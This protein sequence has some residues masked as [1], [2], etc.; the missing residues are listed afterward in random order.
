[1]RGKYRDVI[2]QW[3]FKK[4]DALLEPTKEAVLS[5]IDFQINTAELKE[6]DGRGLR[7]ASG[8]VFYNTSNG[9]FKSYIT[10]R[11]T[12]RLF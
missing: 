7:E 6:L 9:H 8:Y 1:M 5:E 3:S 4:A 10:Q 2:C 12:H 11:Q